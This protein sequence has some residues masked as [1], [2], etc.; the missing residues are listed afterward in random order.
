MEV[1]YGGVSMDDQIA[2]LRRGCHI[3]V[4]TPGRLNDHL[5]RKTLS[6]TAAANIHIR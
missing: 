3:V 1:I 5:R 2:A 6:V 4:G